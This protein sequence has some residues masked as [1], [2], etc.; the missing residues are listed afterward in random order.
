MPEPVADATVSDPT[1]GLVVEPWQARL[2][3]LAMLLV[4]VVGVV[5]AASTVTAI[6]NAREQNAMGDGPLDI[7]GVLRS[8]GQGVGLTAAGAL[9]VALVLVLLGP[10]G[11]IG[12]RGQLALAGLVG[13][14]LLV[15]GA[16]GFAAATYVVGA[17]GSSMGMPMSSEAFNWHQRVGLGAPLVMACALAV[18]VAWTAFSTLAELRPATDDWSA[19]QPGAGPDAGPDAG[20]DAVVDAEEA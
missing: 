6:A 18:Y 7:V 15:S 1:E 11:G 14:G 2:E 4:G 5:L 19:D 17:H 20:S 16:A 8:I 9:V 12:R 3:V 10:G 13:V